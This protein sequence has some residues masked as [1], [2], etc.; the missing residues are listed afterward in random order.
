MRSKIALSGIFTALAVVMVK[1][2]PL[3]YAPV[4]FAGLRRR[5]AWTL[6]FMGVVAAGY[7]GFAALHVPL[8]QPLALEGPL[9]SAGT[10]PYVIESLAGLGFPVGF[11]RTVMVLVLGVTYGLVWRAS[12][13]RTDAARVWSMLWAVAASTLMLLLFANKSWP[14]YLVLILFPLC[15][16]VAGSGLWARVVFALFGIVALVEH[17]FW[18]TLLVEAN[19]AELHRGILRGDGQSL[20]FLLLEVLLVLGYAWLLWEC[21]GRATGE[22]NEMD[23]PAHAAQTER[24]ASLRPRPGGRWRMNSLTP[25]KDLR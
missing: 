3:F 6:C 10:L 11:W 2:I 15:T 8:L 13:G 7:G 22:R 17:S 16:L 14:A 21:V 23:R 18:A 1:L 9:K 4:F 12:I 25:G 19:A 5:S 20:F 24:K